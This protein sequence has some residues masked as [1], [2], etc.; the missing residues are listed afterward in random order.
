MTKDFKTGHLLVHLT[1]GALTFHLVYHHD[2]EYLYLTR[3]FNTNASGDNIFQNTTDFLLH[4]KKALPVLGHNNRE[5]PLHVFEQIF[6][7]ENAEGAGFIQT[8]EGTYHI[9]PE[10]LP[11]NRYQQLLHIQD[12]F[13]NYRHP[14]TLY[15][16]T[17]GL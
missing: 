14:P 15:S 1:R 6:R 12:F 16:P 3:L 7:I 5:H 9:R 2:D 17:G 10:F 13:L 11:H 4:Y 8:L